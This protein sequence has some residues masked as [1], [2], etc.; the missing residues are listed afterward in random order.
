MLAVNCQHPTCASIL[1]E[2]NANPN[3]R[4]MFN[5][6]TL[7]FAVVRNSTSLIEIL[8][9]YR[10]DIEASDQDGITPLFY[11]IFFHCQRAME[12]LLKY[13]ANIHAVDN[14]GRTI[15]MAAVERG[16]PDMVKILL[17]QKINIFARDKQGKDAEDYAISRG[18][19]IIQ[20]QIMEAKKKG[21]ENYNLD[22]KTSDESAVRV[23]HDPCVDSRSKAEDKVLTV[24]TKQCVPE[25]LSE[26][27]PGPSH[28]KG[29]SIVNGK[30]EGA[31][32]SDDSAVRVLRNI[33]VD[34]CTKPKDEGLTATTKQCVPKKL[35]E[36]LPGPSY[37]KRNGVVNEEEDDSWT[38]LNETGMPGASI[39]DDS[40][41]RVFHDL[42]VDSCTKEDKGLTAATKQ[43]VPKKLPEPLPGPSYE[44]GNGVVNDEEE[45][46]L[47]TLN[48]TGMPDA[49][50]SDDS[51]VSIFHDLFV[52]SCKKP[53]DKGLTAATKQCV[54][55][56]LPEPLPGPSYE[57]GNGVVNGEED[58]PWDSDDSAVSVFHDLFVDSCKK[59]KDKGLTAAIKCVPKKL[60]EPLPGPSYE[61]GNGVV[62]GKE[63]DPWDSDDSAVSVFH[64]LSV[65]LC[66]K[67]K[68]KGLTAATKCVPKKLP[69]PLPGPSYEKGNGVVNRK[70]DAGSSD[71]SAE[72]IFQEL[73]VDLCLNPNNEGLAVATKQ[74]V[75]KKMPEPLPGPFHEKGN[76]I[77]NGNG[78][79]SPAKQASLKPTTEVEDSAV[80][81]AVQ[82]KN[83]QTSRAV[84]SEEEQ[85]GL[86]RSEKKQPQKRADI[87]KILMME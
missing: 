73:L 51:V 82:R 77:V 56:K 2:H 87:T 35:P 71:E 62:N 11:S 42:F 29:N 49:W 8:L 22:A 65:D 63:D 10:A 84:T 40:A 30:G 47:T 72:R 5:H 15:L 26:P 74:C 54:P 21:L 66:K 43:C 19:T 1:L 80:K 76:S 83:I 70:E 38:S 4:D 13:N 60:P 27:L 78:E 31:W 39:S 44:K 14:C 53:K 79:G 33:F 69:E 12:C 37:E 75:P 86:K 16:T 45:D 41:V 28:E 57:K 52:D 67:P 81:E 25:K 9:S 61:K 23:L 3:L 85:E 64:D 36:S 58:D 68:D 17:E 46:S 59:P 7:F 48:K 34:S 55:K 20:Q 32:K 24:A 18:S 6:N 50:N